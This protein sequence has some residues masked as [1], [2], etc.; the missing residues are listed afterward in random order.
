MIS[1]YD[2]LH[3]RI[4]APSGD[5]VPWWAVLERRIVFTRNLLLH[6]RGMYEDLTALVSLLETKPVRGEAV[7]EALGLARETLGKINNV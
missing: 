6:S 4:S 2:L 3:E 1:C 5:T 7:E